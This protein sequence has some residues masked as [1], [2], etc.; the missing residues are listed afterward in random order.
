MFFGLTYFNGKWWLSGF[1]VERQVFFLNSAWRVNICGPREIRSTEGSLAV[2]VSAEKWLY[3]TKQDQ[4]VTLK[5]FLLSSCN[6]EKAKM[7]ISASS[8]REMCPRKIK[9][10]NTATKLSNINIQLM[11]VSFISFNTKVTDAKNNLCFSFYTKVGG[12]RDCVVTQSRFSTFSCR[13]HRNEATAGGNLGKI[14]ERTTKTRGTNRHRAW[15]AVS[16]EAAF[17]HF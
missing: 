6:E 10:L 7:R 2:R 1:H 16:V 13:S 4:Q 11:P 5:W 8:N 12:Q 17:T 9:M 3:D 14:R 15:I